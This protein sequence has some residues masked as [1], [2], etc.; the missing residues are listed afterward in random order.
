VAVPPTE[1]VPPLWEEK[2]TLFVVSVTPF[3]DESVTKAVKV[4]VP[5]VLTIDWDE[6]M[7]ILYP[8]DDPL[9]VVP[10]QPA[11]KRKVQ[12]SK[13]KRQRFIIRNWLPE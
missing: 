9:E 7:E 11:I 13:P 4:A 2:L 8:P 6:L 1:K 10:E 12:Q 5:P 3:P